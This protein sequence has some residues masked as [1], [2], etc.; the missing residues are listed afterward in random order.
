MSNYSIPGIVF[1]IHSFY[2]NEDLYVFPVTA[3]LKEAC[4]RNDLCVTCFSF[5]FLSGRSADLPVDSC[6]SKTILSSSQQLVFLLL[7]RTGL[8]APDDCRNP[9][10]LGVCPRDFGAE[11]KEKG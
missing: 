1:L 5:C 6:Q 11:R 3:G 2:N 9:D 8:C 7:G 10:H 4:L